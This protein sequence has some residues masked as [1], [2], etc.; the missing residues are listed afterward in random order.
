MIANTALIVFV[1]I[2][3][4]ARMNCSY[5]CG[6]SSHLKLSVKAS[7]IINEVTIPTTAIP[8]AAGFDFVFK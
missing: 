6:M 8:T 4:N 3:I 2:Q 5:G 7:M 1:M